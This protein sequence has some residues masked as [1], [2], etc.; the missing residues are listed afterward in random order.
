[1]ANTYTLIASNTLSSSASSITFSAIPNTFTDLVVKSSARSASSTSDRDGFKL[2][3]NETLSSSTA[4]SSTQIYGDGSTASSTRSSNNDYIFLRSHL[5][6]NG[7]TASTFG[8]SEIY[9]PN[10]NASTTHPVG[11][12]GVA[13]NNATAGYLSAE[14]GLYGT[15]ESITS[16]KLQTLS[17]SQFVSGSSFFLYGIKNS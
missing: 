16:I 5:D 1:M 8:N 3:F 15:A 14:G 7:L 4:Y 12:F 11:A 9:I 17:G 10:Y 6:R 13:E 2:S